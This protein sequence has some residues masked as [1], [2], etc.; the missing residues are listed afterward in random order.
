MLIASYSPS[1][2]TPVGQAL[3]SLRQPF[4]VAPDDHLSLQSIT[5]LVALAPEGDFSATID[6]RLFR[7]GKHVPFR[8]S[9]ITVSPDT[10]AY[11]PIEVNLTGCALSAGDVLMLDINVGHGGG[12]QQSEVG[13]NLYKVDGHSGSGLLVVAS[14]A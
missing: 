14:I 12:H 9:P 10:A 1:F 5:V 11:L 3:A 8:F 6:L 7:G 2:A 13:S 4:F